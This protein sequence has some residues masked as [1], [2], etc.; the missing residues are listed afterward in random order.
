MYAG[1]VTDAVRPVQ[2]RTAVA[3][4]KKQGPVQNPE[5]VGLE[6][7]PTREDHATVCDVQATHVLRVA[8]SEGE[9]GLGVANPI[10]RGRGMRAPWFG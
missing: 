4:Y 10:V 9:R 7:E 1:A 8:R 3:K 6:K 2:I 5:R